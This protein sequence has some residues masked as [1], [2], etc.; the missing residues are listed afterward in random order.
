MLIFN[1]HWLKQA[2]PGLVTGKLSDFA[3]LAMFPPLLVAWWGLVTREPRVAPE[4]LAGWLIVAGFI[5]AGLLAA[6]K[7]IRP[8]NDA[9]EVGL[10]GLRFLLRWPGSLLGSP[11]PTWHRPQNTMD[12]SDLLAMPAAFWCYVEVRIT[13]RVYRPITDRDAL[14]S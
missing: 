3:G 8:I 1:D 6:I 14:G 13:W 10:G 4:R 11:T 9:Y 2:F 7:T 5:S 12:A